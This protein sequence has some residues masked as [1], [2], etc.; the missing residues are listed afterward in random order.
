MANINGPTNG[1]TNE[2]AN[3]AASG[4][5]N[6]RHGQRPLKIL[7]VGGGMAGLTA[8]IALRKQGHDI[9]VSKSL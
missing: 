8:A 6:E 2:A 4:S 3:E 9:R 5:P 1:V 7:I